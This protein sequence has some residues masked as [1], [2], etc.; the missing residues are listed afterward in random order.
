ML[1]IYIVNRCRF[2][3]SEEF[4]RYIFGKYHNVTADIAR[5]KDGKP[6]AVNLPD[7]HFSISHSGDVMVMA[8]SGCPVGV[9]VEEIK[10]VD[11]DISQIWFT[12]RESQ[13]F[14]SYGGESLKRFFQIWTCKESYSKMLGQGLLMDF[15]SFDIFGLQGVGFK[16]FFADGYVLSLCSETGTVCEKIIHEDRIEGAEF[17]GGE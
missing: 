9:D 1:E 5:T 3:D 14:R 15:G 10:R 2:A 7:L 4:I 16:T 8:V 12:D 17:I 13:Y 11:T 6:Y